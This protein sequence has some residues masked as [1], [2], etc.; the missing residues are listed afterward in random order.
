MVL[1]DQAVDI[2]T[3]SHEPLLWYFFASFFKVESITH[4]QQNYK[5]KSQ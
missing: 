4:S 2:N 5:E 3:E 1:N